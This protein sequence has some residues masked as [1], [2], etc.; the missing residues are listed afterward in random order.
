MR[1]AVVGA[2][3]LGLYY[4]AILQKAGKDVYFLLRSDYEAICS[5]GITVNSVDGNFHLPKVKGFRTASEI[6]TVDL[7]LVG[8]KTFANHLYAELI[9][10]LVGSQTQIITLQNGLGNEENL[11]DLFGEE[12][13]LGGV[14]FLCSNRVKPGVVQHLGEGR[15]LLGEYVRESKSRTELIAAVFRDAGIDCR[16]VS[17][18]QYSRWEKLVWNI[19]FNGLCALML[20]PVES[21]LL[22]EPTRNLIIDIMGEVI[23]AANAQSLKKNVPLSLAEKMV[24]SSKRLGHYKPSMLID[25]LEAHPLE[26]DAIFGVPLRRAYEKGVQMPRVQ[27]LFA[28]L[29]LTEKD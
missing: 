17:D 25:R 15:I 23:S 27:Q 11:A 13:I 8:L 6:G 12:K 18:L 19:P 21:L 10:P 16:I 20:K 24:A 3:A 5:Q 26:L 4:G 1:I 22:F 28:L 9:S 2:G 14:A 7:V 29:Q